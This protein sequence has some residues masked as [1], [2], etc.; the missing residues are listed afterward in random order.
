MKNLGPSR[1]PMHQGLVLLIGVVLGG[2]IGFYMGWVSALDDPQPDAQQQQVVVQPN[3][4]V[5]PKAAVPSTADDAQQAENTQKLPTIGESGQIPSSASPAPSQPLDEP[6]ENLV[7]PGVELRSLSLP[8]RGSLSATFSRN[9][10]GR[11]ADI[12]TAHV[13]RL[14]VWWLDTRREVL[15]GDHIQVVYHPTDDLAQLRILVMSYKSIK[16]GK[17]HRCLLLQAQEG[18]LW[19]VLR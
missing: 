7:V 3:D 11:E 8:V 9:L 17:T 12:L 6:N 14:L 4:V 5:K 1:L 19:K 15:R 10:K 16:N 18:N 13:G 2:G